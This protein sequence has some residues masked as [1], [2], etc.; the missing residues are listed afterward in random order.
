MQEP[1]KKIYYL[2]YF[3]AA[4]KK[5][6]EAELKA[7]LEKSRERNLAA[8]ITGMLMYYDGNFAQV[9]EG[10]Y[11]AVKSAFQKVANDPRHHQII[12]VKEG[13]EEK[14]VFGDWSMAFYPLKAQDFSDVSGFKLFVYKEIFGNQQIAENHPILT[15]LK[16][17]Y[18]N[19]PL[20]RRLFAS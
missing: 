9:L 13:Y 4:R 5:L 10:D 20:Y 17:F 19:Q 1:N 15:V 6:T 8:G 14:R 18:E 3:S 11:Q 7:L 2:M 16:S 12:K